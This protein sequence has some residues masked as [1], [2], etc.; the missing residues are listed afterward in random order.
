VVR[1]CVQLSLHQS[2]F[3]PAAYPACRQEGQPPVS[4]HVHC[5]DPYVKSN[6]PICRGC[7]KQIVHDVL[8][9][10]MPGHKK[11]M[12]MCTRC[13]AKAARGCPFSIGNRSAAP[14]GATAGTR[15]TVLYAFVSAAPTFQSSGLLILW[16]VIIARALHTERT[17]QGACTRAG[18]QS[19]LRFGCCYS[20]ALAVRLHGAEC[21]T[22]HGQRPARAPCPRG[23]SP[24]GGR[25]RRCAR[26]RITV[27]EMAWEPARR[28]A[29]RPTS[30]T[31]PRSPRARTT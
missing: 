12:P 21:R 15:G 3:A 10:T 18:T 7:D 13:A 23:V 11:A 17:S 25:Y 14:S 16:R 8:M 30:S 19:P 6:R 4:L 1:N 5:K 29:S 20:G 27:D 28:S 26:S 24:R 2:L 31:P 22:T 9:V